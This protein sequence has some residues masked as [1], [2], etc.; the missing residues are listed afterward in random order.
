M[1]LRWRL[2]P[3][4]IGPSVRCSG[5]PCAAEKITFEACLTRAEYVLLPKWYL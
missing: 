1:P 4:K 5:L 2:G 3:S